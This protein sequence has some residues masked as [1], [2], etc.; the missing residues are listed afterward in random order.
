MKLRDYKNV[1]CIGIGGIGLSAIARYCHAHGAKVTGSDGHASR[2]TDDLKNEGV[3]VYEGHSGSHVGE[4]VDLVIYT[5]AIKDTNPELAFAR[6]RGVECLTYPEALGML[7][8]EYTTIAVCGTHGKTTT[9]AMVSS[10]L[11]ACGKNPT[12]IVGSI[13][14]D[15]GTNFLQGDSEYLVV[16]AC[17]YKRSFLNLHPSHVLV[18]N[19]D[20]DHLDYYKDLSDIESAFQEFADKLP[21]EGG[22]VT[23]HDV[24][25]ATSAKKINA[26]NIERDS[27]TLSVLG[28]H[29]KSNAQLA[30]AL[31]KTLGLDEES[32]RKGLLS[33]KGT[34]R[35]MEYKGI[36]HDIA[37]YDDY[38][39]HPTEIKA[40]LQ[41]LREKYTQGK[42][43]LIVV[44]QPHLFSRTK[45]LLNEFSES[46]S[47]ADKI[48]ILPIYAAREQDD[49]S[50]SSEDLVELTHNAI[51]M[52]S[53][54]EIEKY[55]L[56]RPHYNTV[57]V[58][59]GAGDVYY[60]HRGRIDVVE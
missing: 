27:V 10:M 19:I 5:I 2:V 57:L 49:E 18:T 39:H 7:T 33:F 58:T 15:G 52:E 55:V 50:I 9:T 37:M 35:R 17:E 16:E 6:K 47:D 44:F 25:L 30:L 11:K 54:E 1:H 22:L 31:A 12:V 20:E 4:E 24:H 56:S 13:L 59:I 32:A 46:F 26:D 51:F 38:G 36:W 21:Q 3:I 43:T 53:F 41:A 34:W 23:H 48:C 45:L 60:F 29:N 14:S 42:Y 40:T 8:K 28:E